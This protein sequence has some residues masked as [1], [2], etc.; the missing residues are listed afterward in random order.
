[1]FCTGLFGTRFSAEGRSLQAHLVLWSVPKRP[2]KGGGAAGAPANTAINDLR[3]GRLGKHCS[4]WLQG[5]GAECSREG[6]SHQN[7]PCA[8]SHEHRTPH[9][10][11]RALTLAS[12]F[13]HSLLAVL[14]YSTISPR[15][16]CGPSS[17]NRLS[18]HS[19]GGGHRW[20]LAAVMRP[21]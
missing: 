17:L 2:S 4:G 9:C 13:C 10:C 8:L 5:R 3:A 1:M 7:A 19:C 18:R 14:G 11:E 6:M 20:S 12:L 21:G 16:S 15:T